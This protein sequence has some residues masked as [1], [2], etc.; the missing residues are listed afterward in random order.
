MVPAEEL[1]RRVANA[2]RRKLAS[3]TLLLDL[4]G[5]LA[6]FAA[7][8]SEA[9]VPVVTKEALAALLTA[10]W[11]VAIVSGRPAAEVSELLDLQGLHIFGSH[12]LEGSWAGSRNSLPPVEPGRRLKALADT[13]RTLAAS[14]PGVLVESKPHGV[15]FHDRR[16]ARQDLTGWRHA[17]DGWL[18]QQD[19][20]GIE[21]LAG[22]RVLELR[23]RGF[24][25][26]RI[27]KEMPRT[28]G[29]PTPDH[30]LVGI[31]DDRTDED[32][33]RELEGLGLS[34]RVGRPGVS[35]LARHRLPSP[36]AVRRFLVSLAIRS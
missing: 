30:S 23:P 36:S 5:T 2:G 24:D 16:V 33:F 25:K 7:T 20:S 15:A 9:R 31:G 10:D 13:G 34:V 35:S 1:A 11:H 12:G 17:L 19:L 28:P 22:A 3:R 32:M 26:G 8:P 4:D 29:L 27:I 21:R 18:D 6:P 14:F